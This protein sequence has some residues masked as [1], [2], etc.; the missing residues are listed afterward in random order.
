[1]PQ[2]IAV[3][4]SPRQHHLVLTL[5]EGTKNLVNKTVEV[6]YRL[7]VVKAVNWKTWTALDPGNQP[8]SITLGG[9]VVDSGD[10]LTFNFDTV[11]RAGLAPG[12]AFTIASGVHTFTYGANGT[13]SLSVA[14][15]ADA[16]VWSGGAHGSGTKVMGL[17][18]YPPSGTV[19][20][21]PSPISLA[22]Q[23]EV[24]PKSANVGDVVT[25]L[26]PRKDSDF[27]HD[28]TWVSG[29]LSGTIGTG[30]ATETPF[31]VPDVTGE[32]PTQTQSPITIT[33]VTKDGSTVIGERSA[34]LL[35]WNEPPSVD[36][37]DLDPYDM[38]IS[39]VQWNGTRLK[40]TNPIIV[41]SLK[42]V[43]TNSS[44]PT[45]QVSTSGVVP[46]SDDD[47]EGAIVV[48]D[49]Q[50]GK[51][52]QSTGLL[53]ALSRSKGDDVEPTDTIN[54][55]GTGYL[56]FLLGRA[57][58]VKDYKRSGSGTNAG[59]IM[60]T[61]FAQAQSRGWGPNLDPGF[62]EH[63][64]SYGD[65]WT[66]SGGTREMSG[67]TPYSQILEAFVND[68]WAEY[69][70]R[71]SDA[72]GIC[73]LDMANP[74]TG[75]DWT[76]SDSQVV[77]NLSTAKISEAPST[78]SMEAV[79]DRVYAQG[80][81]ATNDPSTSADNTAA[82]VASAEVAPY[83]ANEFGRMEGWA[84][85]SGQSTAAGVRE[86]AEN[87]LALATETKSREFTYSAAA[88]SRNLLPYYTFKP[89][90]WILVP[91]DREHSGDPI[92]MR[93][94]QVT[95]DK[96]ADGVTVT[97]V[98]GDL[99]PSGATASLAKR[100]RASSG[101]RI[102]GGTLRD[103]VPVQ[104]L[105]P[106]APNFANEE[107][108]TA[109]GYWN[110]NGEP[111]AYI[112]FSWEP[113]TT[114]ID[115]VTPLTVDY[116][117]VW[118]R[119][120]AGTEWVL[121]TM[122]P[123]TSVEMND[124]PVYFTAQFK[125]R[126]RS[127]AGAFGEFSAWDE[128]TTVEPA[129]DIDGPEIADIYTDG[130]GSIYVTWAGLTGV[131][132][133][134]L[135]L[136][137]VVAEVSDDAGA[138]YVTMGTPITGPGTIVINPGAWG[139]FK[140]RIRAYDKL[141]NPGDASAPSDITLT[142]PQIAPPPTPEA[143]TGLAATPGAGWDST[144]VNA[145][146]W[147]DL[148]WNAVTLDTNGDPVNIAGYDI[149]GNEP[150]DQ[151]H[152]ITSSAVNSTRVYVRN[153]EN[154]SFQVRAA[155]VFG[156]VSA[157]SDSVSAT[158]DATIA[159]PA[160]P[161]APVLSQYAGILRI[162]WSGEGMVPSVRYAYATIS[163]SASGTFTRAGMPLT[164]AGEVVVPG[165]A[166]DETYYAKIVLVDELGQ[167]ATSPVSD[168]LL[169][170]PITGVTIQTSPVANTGIKMTSGSL[171]AYN[172]S[173]DPTFILDAGTGE[174]WIAPYDAVFDLGASGYEAETGDPTTGLA[175][176][177]ESSSFNTFVHASGV[178]IRNDQ[179]PLSWWEADATDAS[180]VNF[181]SPRAVLDQRV[182]MGDYEFLREAKTTGTRLVI[183]YRG[184]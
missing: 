27:T 45:L 23:P 25:V 96:R 116:Y 181:F 140:V 85:A 107:A 165:L 7:Q 155:S 175:I 148:T 21:T 100:L 79:L 41:T 60:R 149:W 103:P 35:V 184:A 142:D 120:S 111:R 17:A 67:G 126:A 31:T 50:N 55:A 97:V 40:R 16:D 156:A 18:S 83:N 36:P 66:T 168:G 147:F 59:N 53:F 115:G 146:A 3:F 52:W 30:I 64:T 5:S 80:D 171:T 135:H 162:G 20:F 98:C 166:T 159:A 68:G 157:F 182:R 73:Y 90:D 136:A 145:T 2:Y 15:S 151:P 76:S 74:L 49:V 95:I 81:A 173:G 22:T 46:G 161:A 33:A 179:T 34:T 47:L 143:P 14:F 99:I 153:F 54:W 94:S 114:A 61:L 1:M 163:T 124:W 160:A 121:R 129:A 132:F 51:T 128:V 150:G 77:V 130:L 178:Q 110:S 176:S 4:P 102:S 134:P 167:T 106:A 48:L 78:W 86:V 38:R 119:P 6:A 9:V 123:T 112:T 101:N 62:P 125:V 71:F 32:F 84:S 69:R 113:V 12:T 109:V 44:T 172:A 75:S 58:L 8:W 39:R 105:V 28:V 122:T 88:V 19:N 118:W 24:V 108:A 92:S 104:Q 183:R 154:W 26:L 91:S 57:Y 10:A 158:A 87:A 139:D 152:F 137:Y 170:E 89:G 141:G 29:E 42:L 63:K 174:V 11:T 82:P 127:S 56:D 93:V 169:L 180:L 177:S 13:L 37:A 43:D 65:G 117:E 70:T 164:G 131:S 72:D 138:T 144:G 133:A